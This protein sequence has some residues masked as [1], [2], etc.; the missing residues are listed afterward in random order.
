[1][2]IIKNFKLLYQDSKRSHTS[3]KDSDNTPAKETKISSNESE[4]D[5]QDDEEE[6]CS[7][8]R[9]Q[10]KHYLAAES[11]N[12][13]ACELYDDWWYVFCFNCTNNHLKDFTCQKYAKY[14]NY[15]HF[16]FLETWILGR[17]YFFKCT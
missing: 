4:S 9:C 16:L 8:P 12:W 5:K 14:L 2:K 7:S 6:P 3:D 13:A 1:M 11:I 15:Y 10:I 17:W